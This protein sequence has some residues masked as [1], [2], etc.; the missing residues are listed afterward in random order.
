MNRL[1]K[2]SWWTK[3][4]RSILVA[5]VAAAG[6]GAPEWVRSTETPWEIVAELARSF[7]LVYVLSR[8]LEKER[9]KTWMDAC[10]LGAGVSLF[11]AAILLGSVIHE[12]MPI[13]KYAVRGGFA[14]GST[15]VA[16][17]VLSLFDGFGPRRRSGEARVAG[18]AADSTRARPEVNYK[19]V[20]LA[21]I[22]AITVGG[23]WYSP[24]LFG[25]A[26][27]HL[28]AG[29]SATGAAPPAVELLGELI[30]SGTVA[31]IL[32]RWAH[33]LRLTARGSLLLGGAMWLGFHSTLL[34]FSVIH[35]HMP[36]ALFAIH[37]GHGL[38]NDLVIAGI[39]GTWRKKVQ[40][41]PSHSAS[42]DAATEPLIGP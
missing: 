9:T 29:A 33:E 18:R 26:W 30:R 2:T 11:Q 12:H 31:Y 14:I 36:L 8:L 32:A 38:A 35:E 42:R 39:V 40:R 21:P 4:N 19:A 28:K 20:V 27:A 1:D 3:A 16:V 41:T 13:A 37:A 34:L 25:G 22:V 17:V 10:V 5:A 24:L 6:F 23:L 7:L 15:L